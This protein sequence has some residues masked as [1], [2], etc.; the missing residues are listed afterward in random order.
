MHTFF[1]IFTI[2]ISHY[3]IRRL[4]GDYFCKHLLGDSEN[5]IDIQY[6]NENE[7]E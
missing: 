1:F 6:I 5:R 3:F 2:Y 7:R 4:T